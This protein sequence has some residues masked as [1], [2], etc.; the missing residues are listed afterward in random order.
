MA[1]FE[2]NYL[3]NISPLSTHLFNGPY[4]VSSEM[5]E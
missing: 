1:N 2:I 4:E 5:S 3:I